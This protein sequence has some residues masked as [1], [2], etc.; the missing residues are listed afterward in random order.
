MVRTRIVAPTVLALL[1][2]A[3]MTG[4]GG[5]GGGGSAAG[6]STIMGNVANESAALRA[7]RPSTMIVQLRKFLSPVSVADADIANIMV[8]IEGLDEETQTDANGFFAISAVPAGTVTIMF[9]AGAASFSLVIDVPMNTT[10]V[11]HDVVLAEGHA[12]PARIEMNAMGMGMPM[13]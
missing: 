11:L 12:K 2:M 13:M 5:S 8:K 9:M 3:A 6:S 7:P 1:L 4:C 10:V